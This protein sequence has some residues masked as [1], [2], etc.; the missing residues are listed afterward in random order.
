MAEDDYHLPAYPPFQE[1]TPTNRGPAVVVATYIYLV[2]AWMAVL[3]QL[4]MKLST[5][6]RLTSNDH[7]MI[8]SIILATAQSIALTVSCNKGLGQHIDDISSD[9]LDAMSQAYYASNILLVLALAAAKA[10]VIF[11]IISIKPSKSVMLG[12]RIVLATIALWA[13]AC[14][15]T[16]AFQCGL[17]RPWVLGPNTQE[18]ATCLNQFGL[19]I[20]IAVTNILTDLAV[21]AL[22]LV[23]M[24]QV[25]TARDKKLVVSILFGLRI[26]TPVFAITAIILSQ[27]FY[28]TSPQDR[29]WYAVTPAIWTQ[30]MLNVSIIT[31]CIPSIKR[32]LGNIRSGLTTINISTNYEAT[33]YGQSS[34]RLDA[35]VGSKAYMHGGGRRASTLASR[36]A[37]SLRLSVVGTSNMQHSSSGGGSS[38]GRSGRHEK[39][40]P[41]DGDMHVEFGRTPGSRVTVG[42]TTGE[43]S[44]VTG[45]TDDIIMHTIDY[46]VEYV[47]AGSD[48]E[49]VGS[50]GGRPST[51]TRRTGPNSPRT[52]VFSI[53]S[54]NTSVG[55]GV[56]R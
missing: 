15:F 42:S 51:S 6:R 40:S 29:T 28:N 11:L 1:L 41:V 47:D 34:G 43:S 37:S 33:R 23:M 48:D 32:F 44:S 50:L 55:V 21:I 22:P 19:Q 2:I 56:A 16:L 46:K 54:H 31:A 3:V 18:P 38:A 13:V 26:F 24:S 27:D 39:R 45:L 53:Q 30:L 14:T 49:E 20:G 4:W 12:C 52:D 7:C 9:N 35:T 17:P 5:S 25:Q 10:S 36:L 8:A